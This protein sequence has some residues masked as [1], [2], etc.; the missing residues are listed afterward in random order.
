MLD[1][2]HDRGEKAES[3]ARRDR[4][5]AAKA[6]PRPGRGA[7]P[8][9]ATRLRSDLDVERLENRLALTAGISFD[10]RSRVLT[11]EGTD[12]DDVVTVTV[13]QSRQGPLVVATLQTSERT[14]SRSVPASSV[15]RIDFVAL[16]GDDSFMNLTGVPS[17][18]DGGSGDDRLVGGAGRDRLVGGAG[19]DWLEGRGGN[20]VLI[21]GDDDDRLEGGAGAD[22]LDAGDG[23]DA[24]LG[25][26]GADTMLGGGGDDL[27]DGG[28]GNDLMRGGDGEDVMH[29]GDGDDRLD[30][31]GGTDK[32]WGGNGRD[33]LDGGPG[34]DT[35][36]GDAGDDVLRG[37]DDIDHLLGGD[38][39]DVLFGGGDDDNVDG[40]AG[41]DLLYGDDG[42]DHVDG[43]SGNDVLYGGNGDD[44]VI[45][46][47]G[48]DALFGGE[49]DDWLDGNQGRDII[50]G[51][52][53]ND[54]CFDDDG[55]VDRS[56]ADDGDNTLARGG[57]DVFPMSL[58]FDDS[59]VAVVEGTSASRRDR[60]RF[61]FVAPPGG[62]IAVTV[63]GHAATGTGLGLC[64]E[65][66]I[67][68]AGVEQP[69]LSIRPRGTETGSG[70]VTLVP[71]RQYQLWVRSQTM[72]PMDFIVEL[73]SV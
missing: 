48:N 12:Q 71:G 64:A 23:M 42:N 28:S 60:S 25:G 22:S 62:D 33:T 59:G 52:N 68:E 51:G 24:L 31:N 46:N 49:G 41:N 6:I 21:G 61:D 50:R 16:A 18:V 53:G 58:V 15:A 54:D 67:E 45:G 7:A 20:D 69:L 4:A 5:A 36:D 40:E 73:R 30:G 19:K 9:L 38:G 39:D 34:I 66:Q 55:M 72:D 8:R 65:V 47:L 17:V 56:A 1:H 13:R 44:E 14:S 26:A 70:R 10:A 29:G 63:S 3:P 57:R 37:G 2:D 27:M 11:I 32:L 43:G 35:V